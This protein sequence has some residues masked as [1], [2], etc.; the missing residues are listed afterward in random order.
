MMRLIAAGLAKQGLVPPPVQA[1]GARVPRASKQGFLGQTAQ[2]HGTRAVLALSDAVPDMPPE[3][4][5]LALRQARDMAD[6]LER[7]RRVE[8]FSHATHRVLATET[9]P[10]CYALK[11]VGPDGGPQPSHPESLLVLGVVTVLGELA[12]KRNYTVKT[13]VGTKLRLRGAWRDADLADWD[14]TVHLFAEE[15]ASRA[16]PS[17]TEVQGDLVSAAK[18]LVSRD[19]VRRWS[20]EDL[21]SELGVSTRTLQRRFTEGSVTFSDLV[22]RA[23]LEKAAAY[24]CN[25]N[26]PGLAETGF[27]A[28]YSDQ[29]HFSRTFTAQ[30]GTTPSDYRRKFMA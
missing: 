5:V 7:W 15:P 23:R 16:V 24:L 29:A 3:P 20:V 30:V 27:L 28:G 12:A 8:V 17:G 2:A 10:G 21:A 1:R 22:G 25:R 13:A 4:V 14:Q 6:L 18:E 26:G 9:A 19:L 11:H